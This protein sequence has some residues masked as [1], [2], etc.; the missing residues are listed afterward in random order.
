M[1]F[2]LGWLKDYLETDASLDTIL[3][4]LNRIGLEVEGV[5]NPA[6]TLGAFKVAHVVDVVKHPDADKLKVCTV[7]TGSET[8]TVVCGAPNARAD[9]KVVLGRPGDYVPGL[10]VTL[11]LRPV[12]GVESNGMMCSSAELNLGEDSDG[13]MDL[14]ADAPIGESYIDYAGLNDP[15]I[16]IAITPNRQ[17]CLG[18]YGIARDLA[19]AGVGTLK[20]YDVP[21]LDASV[22][23]PVS[24]SAQHDGTPF[25]IG[26]YIS[27]VQNGDS[28]A[29]LKNR[30]E[31]IG[32]RSI[33][34]LVDITNYISY[35]FGRPLHVYDAA[36]VSG[37]IVTRAAEAGE[38][39]TALDEKDYLCEGGESV[40]ADDN[41]I[42][43]FAGIIGGLASGVSEET[44]DVIL[45]IGYFAPVRAAM[46]GRT[47]NIITDARYRAERG[48]DAAFMQDGSKIA[49][50][51]I[52]DLCG[53][54]VSKPFT[55]GTQP[56]LDKTISFRSERVRTLGG[57][58][59]PAADSVAIL[60]KLGFA[61][62]GDDPCAVKV[63]SWRRDVE[64]EADLVEEVLRIHGYDEIPSVQLPVIDHKAGS[65]LGSNQKRARAAK[66]AM[67]G[68]GLSEAMTWSFMPRALAEV[69]GGG[70]DRLVVDNPISSD[71][72]CMRPSILP[73]LAQAAQRNQDRGASVIGLF[74]V[75]PVYLDDTDKGQL[76]VV[77]GLRAGNK[78]DRHWSRS[79]TDGVGVFDAKAD[80]LTALDAA[81]A[82]TTNLQ[83]FAEAPDYFHPGRSG[84]LRL[85][86][87]NILAAFGELH[88]AVSKK[89]GMDGPVVGFE[90][91]LDR[92]PAPKKAGGA[93]KGAMNIS[94]LQSVER[95]FAFL[96]DKTIPAEKLLRA[97]R[98]A[99]KKFIRDVTLFDLYDGQGVP[100]GKVSIA[101]SVTL[102]P[103]GETFSD[104]I[105]ESI[106]D[107]IIKA[108]EKSTGALLRG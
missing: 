49:A 48:L 108:A 18:V 17:D 53:G 29:W 22:D 20:A 98:G 71:L 7:D 51:M 11:A 2:T 4:T 15:V 90:V 38:S 14:P 102:E 95:D 12:R 91:Y 74:E 3:D 24:V 57:L 104:K 94:N 46:T 9:M 43:G 37:N 100:E 26:Y 84:T 97:I 62:D 61:V 73:N 106:S 5:E 27:G 93:A 40:I 99:D 25:Y 75:G 21:T 78:T 80:A 83:V 35:E 60:K 47:H 16:E 86:P 13:I 76:L 1:K 64:G 85:G 105:I 6:D 88:P 77:A 103:Q 81:G 67:A 44:T 33:S 42:L 41:G 10:D 89:L 28:P 45:E 31:A 65:T 8:I 59:L 32:L 63:P 34:A 58:D 107:T 54:T 56:S 36:K 52:L 96:V 72:D 101:L 79:G 69:F 87:K 68:R 66:R 82:P 55:D 30:L 50:Q 23:S 92:I 39:F 19:A 70:D